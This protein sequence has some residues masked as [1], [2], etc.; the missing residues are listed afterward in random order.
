LAPNHP[1]VGR[2]KKNFKIQAKVWRWPGDAGWHFV[3]VDKAISAEIR[4]SHPKGFVYIKA[5]VGKTEWDTALFP[6][7]LSA[8]YLLSVKAIV[9]KKEGIFEGDT[10][11]IRFAIK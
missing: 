2:M 6:H 11:E 4:K 10:V 9:R 5:K 3:N 1:F 8:S 7:K